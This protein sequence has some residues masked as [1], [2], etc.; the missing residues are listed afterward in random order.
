LLYD[1]VGGELRQDIPHPIPVDVIVVE[2]LKQKVKVVIVVEQEFARRDF[3]LLF[4]WGF[5]GLGY[6]ILQM[7]ESSK[8]KE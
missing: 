7:N 1:W 5:F 2:E 6:I 4:D 8:K 3:A